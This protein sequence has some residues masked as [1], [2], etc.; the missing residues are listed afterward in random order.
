VT[1]DEAHELIGHPVVDADGRRLGR[2]VGITH[3]WNG[4]MSALVSCR[5]R[6]RL[7]GLQV[8]LAGAVLVDGS[9]QLPDSSRDLVPH[10]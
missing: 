2:V 7:S 3:H 5:S 8:E 9:V 1:P 6:L 10:R 4:G